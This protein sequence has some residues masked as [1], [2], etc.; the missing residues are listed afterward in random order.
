M[1]DLIRCDSETFCDLRDNRYAW[2]P[3][4]R[5]SIAP[6]LSDARRRLWHEWEHLRPD[7][8]LKSGASFRMRRMGYFELTPTT[9]ELRS[10]SQ[11]VYYQ[12]PDV[13]RY[14]G[15]IDRQFAPLRD[16]TVANP[17]LRELIRFDF[18]QFPVA[19]WEDVR[20]WTVD[21]HMFRII[22]QPDEVGEP[23]PEGIHHD[24]DEFN[25][26]HLVQRQNVVGGVS[27]V[28]DNDRCLLQSVTLRESMDSLI[29]WDP[30]VMHGVSPIR[31]KTSGQPAIRDVLVIGYNPDRSVAFLE[32]EMP[33][34]LP[35]DPEVMSRSGS[36][37]GGQ[38]AE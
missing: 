7:R 4:S 15:G 29:L 37:A 36:G 24:G 25:A 2:V 20:T 23:T 17:F 5:F 35:T 1:I 13:N 14:A 21:I 26:V 32:A 38:N 22:G 18:S 19:G 16:S 34:P 12:S 30:H 11:A 8:Y 27:G 28:Y 33:R 10:L 9:G 6:R 3:A 31:P